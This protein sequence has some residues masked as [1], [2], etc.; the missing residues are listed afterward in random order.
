MHR[1]KTHLTFH[2]SEN[3]TWFAIVLQFT[4]HQIEIHIA[5]HA[6]QKGWGLHQV[7]EASNCPGLTLLSSTT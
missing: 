4:C 5:K 3:L 7:C 2:I 1:E 6:W